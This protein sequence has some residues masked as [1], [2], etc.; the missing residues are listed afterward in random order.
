M[1]YYFTR[2]HRAAV[3]VFFVW[4]LKREE[5]SLFLK[6]D[7]NLFVS[8]RNAWNGWT[9]ARVSAS[10][11]VQREKFIWRKIVH[12]GTRL[13][14]RSLEYISLSVFHFHLA[15]YSANGFIFLSI[16][17]RFSS[18]RT[19]TRSF[20][21]LF[22]SL[23]SHSCC[24]MLVLHARALVHSPQYNSHCTFIIGSTLQNESLA[25]AVLL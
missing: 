6:T 12:R 20:A 14:S 15:I 13:R 19:L 18:A 17:V 1:L 16:I 23:F 2:R 3:F 9:R 10:A 7:E 21:L 4:M 22:Y 8:I 24:R 5:N 25:T 11:N